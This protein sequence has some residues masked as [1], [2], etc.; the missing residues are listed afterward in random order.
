MHEEMVSAAGDQNVWIVGGGDLVGRFADVGLLDEIVDRAGHA[1]RWCASPA[2]P[3]RAASGRDGTKRGLRRRQVLGRAPTRLTLSAI[4]ASAR[5][6]FG[7]LLCFAAAARP[8]APAAPALELS[9]KSQPHCART[10]A[11]APLW[12]CSEQVDCAQ[13]ELVAQVVQS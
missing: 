6:V 11:R 9:M 13:G 3:D 8:V 10:D 2:A 5:R 7:R 4:T 1:R 12:E